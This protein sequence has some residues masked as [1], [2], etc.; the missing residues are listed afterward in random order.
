MTI[1][2]DRLRSLFAAVKAAAEAAEDTADASLDAACAS[3]DAVEFAD[4]AANLIGEDEAEFAVTDAV[5]VT[6][7]AAEAAHATD[8]A[9]ER[10]ARLAAAAAIL[11]ADLIEDLD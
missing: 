10:A 6:N 3:T 4:R 8:R 2:T 5:F 7:K 9:A 1:S 11:A